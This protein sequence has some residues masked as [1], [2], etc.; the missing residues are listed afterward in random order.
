M[1][2]LALDF[3]STGEPTYWPSDP[4]K[5]PDLIDFGIIKGLPKKFIEVKSLLE[6]SSDHSPILITLNNRIIEKE[7][8]CMLHNKKTN[9]PY[10][11]ELIKSSI[12]IALP[13]KTEENINNAV[14]HFNACIQQEATWKATP[15]F[16][17]TDNEHD[18][19]R[20]ILELLAEKRLIRKKWQIFRCLR[21]KTKK[22]K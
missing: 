6:L 15:E 1:E 21:L 7:K 9:W 11:R 22:I 16:P 5:T 10:F 14:E 2:A 18:C 19:S 3:I 12:N 8:P 13:L 20:N 4:A 17:N